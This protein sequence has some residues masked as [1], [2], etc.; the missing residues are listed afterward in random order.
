[1][2]LVAFV[3]LVSLVPWAFALLC[4]ALGIGWKLAMSPVTWTDTTYLPELEHMV[5]P[6]V[7][8]FCILLALAL[9]PGVNAAIVGSFLGEPMHK[10]FFRD[11][12]RQARLSILG[13]LPFGLAA[14]GI[15]ATIA[16]A[17]A[18]TDHYIEQHHLERIVLASALLIAPLLFWAAAWLHRSRAAMVRAERTLSAWQAILRGRHGA[19]SARSWLATAAPFTLATVL[20]LLLLWLRWPGFIPLGFAL[21]RVYSI[22]SHIVSRRAF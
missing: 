21:A 14:I 12:G 22:R 11:Y 20:M 4:F 6:G 15:A 19:F 16:G 13:I 18:L 7:V 2:M 1:M 17:S 8:A 10:A 5:S 9:R 3:W